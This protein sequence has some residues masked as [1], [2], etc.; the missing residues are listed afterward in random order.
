MF[1]S[2]GRYSRVMS[3][4]CNKGEGWQPNETDVCIIRGGWYRI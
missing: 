1:V 4:V 3:D 2:R